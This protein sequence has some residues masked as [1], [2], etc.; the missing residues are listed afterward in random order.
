MSPDLELRTSL[1]IVFWRYGYYQ[2]NSKK[3]VSPE[4]CHRVAQSLDCNGNHM[5]KHPDSNTFSYGGEPTWTSQWLA[6]TTTSVLNCVVED[7]ELT[8]NPDTGEISSIMGPLGN[9][10][11]KGHGTI[12]FVTFIWSPNDATKKE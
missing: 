12:N 1:P 9:E 7:T 3:E 11:L 2:S 4:E 10:I 8:V 6:T 5:V